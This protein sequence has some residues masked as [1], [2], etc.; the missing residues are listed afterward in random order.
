MDDMNVSKIIGRFRYDKFKE[1]LKRI[2]ESTEYE[3][4]EKKRYTRFNE[5]TRNKLVGARIE[6]YVA[7][8]EGYIKNGNLP[9]HSND[10]PMSRV[11]GEFFIATNDIEISALYGTS[12][13]NI[14]V[15]EKVKFLGGELGHNNIYLLD[16]YKHLGYFVPLYSDIYPEKLIV[17]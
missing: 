14:I 10:Y 7:W 9:T 16:G 4:E 3:L 2:N 1:E 12:A 17:L 15:P 6:D 5:L 11:I 8:L 13:I